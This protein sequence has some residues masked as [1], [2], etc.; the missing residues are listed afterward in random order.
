MHIGSADAHGIH[1][2]LDLTRSGIVDRLLREAEFALRGQF[3]NQ[4]LDPL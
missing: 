3:G 2:H 1:P 4:H